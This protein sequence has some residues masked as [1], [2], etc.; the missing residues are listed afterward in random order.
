MLNPDN[1]FGLAHDYADNGSYTVTVS[2]TDPE[3]LT[4]TDTVTVTVNNVAPFAMVSNNGPVDEGSPVTVTLVNGADPSPTDTAAGF[5]YSYAL[6][7]ASLATSY[8]DAID[9]ASKDFTFADDGIY[10]TH[11]P[12]FRQERRLQRVQHGGDRQ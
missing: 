2:I 1:S 12:H 4:S 11:A 8:A 6:D 9:G 10:A 3:G 7:T 5:H